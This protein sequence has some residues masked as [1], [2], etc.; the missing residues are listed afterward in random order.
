MSESRDDLI[1]ELVGR[2]PVREV[3]EVVGL[4]PQ[5][6]YQILERRGVPTPRQRD[7]TDSTHAA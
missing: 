7:L 2:L 3:A 5:R 4:S 1:V 6:I